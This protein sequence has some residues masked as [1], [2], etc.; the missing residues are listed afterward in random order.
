MLVLSDRNGTVKPL[1]DFASRLDRLFDTPHSAVAP[2]NIYRTGGGYEI[3]IDL[4]G[5]TSD[6]VDVELKD[7]RICVSAERQTREQSNVI[8]CEQPAGRITR[9]FVL[10]EDADGKSIEANL[11]DGV[12]TVRVGI[13]PE[14]RRKIAVKSG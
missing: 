6:K 8:H 9:S 13:D 3:D 10:P 11:K 14:S 4:P 1:M 12:L 5:V 7:G 2:A